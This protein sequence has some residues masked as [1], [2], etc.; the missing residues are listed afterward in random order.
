MSFLDNSGLQSFVFRFIMGS[1]RINISWENLRPALGKLVSSNFNKKEWSPAI[2]FNVL[3]RFL[4]T[5]LLIFLAIYVDFSES[6]PSSRPSGYTFDPSSLTS[7][8][9]PTRF[10]TQMPSKFHIKS[11]STLS[12]IWRNIRTSF[13]KLHIET[14]ANFRG[15][16]NTIAF[17]SQNKYFAFT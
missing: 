3:T 7:K 17:F 4:Y 11:F 12:F 16:T 15:F 14:L 10:L 2:S 1:V 8:N 9:T 6:S 5:V 13:T